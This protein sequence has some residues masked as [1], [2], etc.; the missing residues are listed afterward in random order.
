M[1]ANN[2]RDWLDLLAAALGPALLAFLGGLARHFFHN[3]KSLRAFVASCIMS[4]FSGV[5]TFWLLDMVDI[6]TPVM[7]A[8]V[9]LAGYS[10]GSI[11][12]SIMDRLHREIRHAKLP[13]VTSQEL[14]RDD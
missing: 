1:P 14:G 2:L 6:S 12:E 8:C 11:I 4:I 9:S 10:G 3:G 7:A 13:Y 5:L